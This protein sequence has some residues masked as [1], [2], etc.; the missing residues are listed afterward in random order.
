MKT[1]KWLLAS[2]LSKPLLLWLANQSPVQYM[3]FLQSP[4][5]LAIPK[6]APTQVT[7]VKHTFGRYRIQTTVKSNRNV[8]KKTTHKKGNNK[9]NIVRFFN[10]GNLMVVGNHFTWLGLCSKCMPLKSK[11]N[12][13]EFLLYERISRVKKSLSK[14]SIFSDTKSNLFNCKKTS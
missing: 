8:P 11:K 1:N 5:F 4:I 6:T 10:Q 3:N 14:E 13:I 7:S 9:F 2:R 12:S